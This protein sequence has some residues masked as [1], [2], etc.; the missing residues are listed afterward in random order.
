MDLL[1][2]LVVVPLLAAGLIVLMPAKAENAVRWIAVSAAGITLAIGIW[3]FHLALTGGN[4]ALIDYTAGLPRIPWV[5]SVGITW[6][7]GVDGMS[8]AMILLNSLVL[9]AGCMISAHAIRDRVKE[10]TSRSS[11]RSCRCTC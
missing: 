4:S 6:A 11:W 9:F 1:T 5:E 3:F 8:V 10:C 7:V 2:L